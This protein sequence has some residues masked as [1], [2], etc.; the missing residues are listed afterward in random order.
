MKASLVVFAVCGIWIAVS[1]SASEL[2]GR[3]SVIDGDT[4]EIHG[5]RARL[6]GIDAPESRQLCSF[7]DG[8]S[9]PCGQRAAFALAD[10]IGS[11]TVSCRIEGQDRYGR[12]LA[13]CAVG[14]ADLGEWLVS[15]GWAVPYYD[16]A[17]NYRAA[18]DHAV[19]ARLGIWQGE[20]EMPKDWRGRQRNR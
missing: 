2:A 6:A 13:L 15:N 3:A 9:W 5:Y 19:A 11:R 20:F 4:I 1:G 16:R 7:S 12:A 18:R 10:R 14:R 17:G 8:R